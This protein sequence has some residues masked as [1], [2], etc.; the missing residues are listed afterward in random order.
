MLGLQIESSH[1]TFPVYPPNIMSMYSLFFL[2]HPPHPPPLSLYL[3]PFPFP[4]RS[5]S[6]FPLLFLLSVPFLSSP[7]VCSPFP[8]LT[9]FVT[10]C[11]ALSLGLFFCHSVSL[12]R[13]HV[14]SSW[15]CS[16][17]SHSVSFSVTL[18]LSLAP[19]YSH[20]DSVLLSQRSLIWAS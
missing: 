19:M 9:S 1:F 5:L 12:S 13:F 16:T 2:P 15:F 6:H 20:S 10:V 4:P 14:L 11:L 17:L 18:S 7:C 8:C 3:T